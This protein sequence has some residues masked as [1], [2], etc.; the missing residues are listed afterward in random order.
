MYKYYFYNNYMMGLNKNF[1]L[2]ES[3][4][5]DELFDKIL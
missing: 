1:I 4:Y 2:S 3:V 5:Y